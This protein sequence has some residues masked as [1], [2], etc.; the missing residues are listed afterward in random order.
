MGNRFIIFLQFSLL[1]IYIIIIII[2]I[3]ILLYNIAYLFTRTTTL[4]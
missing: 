1:N 4:T 2:I 3:I